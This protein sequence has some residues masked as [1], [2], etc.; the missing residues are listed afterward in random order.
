MERFPML[1]FV[2]RFGT[3]ATTLLALISAALIVLLAW[4]ALGWTAGV[5]AV[6]VAAVIFV[7]GK[8]FVELVV[9]VTEMLVPR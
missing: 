2:L 8:S 1:A 9:I 7:A 6:L 4:P 3:V 5:V